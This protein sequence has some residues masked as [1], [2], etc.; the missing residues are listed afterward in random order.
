MEPKATS[1]LIVD[2]DASITATLCIYLK[3]RGY[4]VGIAGNGREALEHLKR[5]QYDIIVTDLAMPEMNGY[6]LLE[7]VK[8]DYR[9]HKVIAVSSNI[10]NRTTLLQK[11]AL[12]ALEKPFDLE[13]LLNEI[14]KLHQEKRKSKRFFTD[15]GRTLTCV[16][17]DKLSKGELPCLLANISIDGAML[18]TNGEVPFIEVY[19]DFSISTASSMVIRM[20]G[21]VVRKFQENGRWMTGVYFDD[22]RDLSLLEQLTP[23][24]DIQKGLART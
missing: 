9:E 14:R 19:I 13:D 23:Y 18:Q 10:S 2:D 16:L 21:K 22:Q 11:G 17:R 15:E 5:G 24:L 1:I 4:K 3:K 8:T 6:Q 7:T 20:P 12:E